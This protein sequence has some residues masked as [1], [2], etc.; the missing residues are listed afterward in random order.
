MIHEQTYFLEAN[1]KLAFENQ[2]ERYHCAVRTGSTP[3]CIHQPSP[4]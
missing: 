1:W 3:G 2:M 4:V